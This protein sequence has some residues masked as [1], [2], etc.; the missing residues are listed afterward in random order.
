M[1]KI[2]V[3][4]IMKIDELIKWAREKSGAIIWQKILYNRQK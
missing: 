3:E 2:K 4:K 1:M